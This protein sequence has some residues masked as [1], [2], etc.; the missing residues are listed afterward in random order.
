MN[1]GVLTKIEALERDL[2]ALQR[3]NPWKLEREI[4][5]L[6]K[7]LNAE[8]ATERDYL[9]ERLFTIAATAL[10]TAGIMRSN[11]SIPFL[12]QQ[13][14]AEQVS[15]SFSS[16]LEAGLA[17]PQ[18]KAAP[19]L[20]KPSTKPQ[21]KPLKLPTK[22]T[23][24]FRAGLA[25]TLSNPIV[26]EAKPTSKPTSKPGLNFADKVKQ[27]A[28]NIGA[29]PVDLLTLM[30]FETAGTLSPTKRG[31][32][33]PGQGRA[34]GLIQFMPG[35]AHGLGTS[36]EA[37]ADMTPIEQM[38]FVEKYLQMRGFKGGGLK[39]LY[40]T[41]FAGYPDA[42][43]T[44]SDGYHTLDSAV[45]RMNR[46]HRPRALEILNG[47]SGSKFADTKAII[48]SWKEKFQQ[49]PVVGEMIG[50]YPVTSVRGWRD[51][52][53]LGRQKFHDGVDLATPEGTPIYAIA[54]GQLTCG[55]ESNGGIYASF[56]SDKFPN[57]R[58]DSYHLSKCAATTNEPKAVREGEVIGWTGNTGGSTGPHL[59]LE[60]NSTISGN[61]LRVR[62]GWLH[63]FT[64]GKA[65]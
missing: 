65:P 56:T 15:P 57:L 35:T 1:T 40:S 21:A 5:N 29:D 32:E 4:D 16:G 34:I 31:P 9:R 30:S 50:G 27:V 64:T 52:P 48:A 53:I 58:F 44:I 61:S 25:N 51:H 2:L 41:V 12:N 8:P 60:I 59:H 17:K 47:A 37:L 55:T 19:D 11:P 7:A 14:K 18:T 49:D 46:E 38:D 33:V 23:A 3:K 63:W 22:P 45:E 54:D 62:S 6:L 26:G 39:K 28:A 10:L 42:P 20:A 43:G 13:P 36:V 24:E